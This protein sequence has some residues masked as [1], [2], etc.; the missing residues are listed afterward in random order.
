MDDE[1]ISRKHT[2]GHFVGSNQLWNF[3]E[4]YQT[5]RKPMNADDEDGAT[6][7]DDKAPF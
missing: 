5:D 6:T 4:S 3:G 7:A 2:K 1:G